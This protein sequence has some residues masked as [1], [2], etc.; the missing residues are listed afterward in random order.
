[1]LWGTDAR[2]LCF[3][4]VLNTSARMVVWWTIL[5]AYQKC[6][7]VC[8]N[9]CVGHRTCARDI[10]L[11]GT[12][13]GTSQTLSASPGPVDSWKPTLEQKPGFARIPRVSMEPKSLPRSPGW[14]GELFFAGAGGL[15]SRP[16][17]ADSR[18]PMADKKPGFARIPRVSME[19][20]SRPW[21]PGMARGM[22]F[23]RV[24]HPD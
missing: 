9:I 16:G 22:V 8:Q 5:R 12:L 19:P 6:S 10:T 14:P 18:K 20:K 13:P 21:S 4:R 17:P 24:L 23:L 2:A 11:P 15:V 3:A 7:T 1:M